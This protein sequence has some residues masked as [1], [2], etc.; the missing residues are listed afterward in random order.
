[1]IEFKIKKDDT[2]PPLKVTVKDGAGNIIDLTS[3]TAKLRLLNS[4]GAQV[5]LKDAIVVSPGSSG[6]LQYDW[7]AAD[8]VTAGE[9]IADFKVTLPSTAKLSAPSDDYI[10]VTILG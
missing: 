9:F 5:F 2:N 4:L 10:R 8:T 6:Q 7:V 1:M 3:A